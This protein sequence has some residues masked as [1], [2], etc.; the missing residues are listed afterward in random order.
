MNTKPTPT[1]YRSKNFSHPLW[2]KKNLLTHQNVHETPQHIKW[3]LP[4]STHNLKYYQEVATLLASY[5]VTREWGTNQL[6]SFYLIDLPIPIFIRTHFKLDIND[7]QKKIIKIQ[8]SCNFRH[9]VKAKLGIF[10]DSKRVPFFF[11]SGM[12]S[13]PNHRSVQ[14]HAWC[15]KTYSFP[16][17]CV[18]WW[19]QILAK[20][21][22]WDG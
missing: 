17:V 5:L 4:K 6:I 14:D 18:R 19:I 10:L 20:W 15:W 11:Q 9:Q 16:C 1:P 21:P 2:G 13:Y 8:I 22:P 3:L 7:F 12:D